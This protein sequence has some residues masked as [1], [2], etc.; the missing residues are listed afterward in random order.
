MKDTPS[1]LDIIFCKKGKIIDICKGVPFSTES[2]G[3]NE[4]SD[5]VIELPF[6]HAIKFKIKLGDK[7]ELLKDSSIS[8]SDKLLKIAQKIKKQ[9]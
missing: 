6:G 2:V 4:P 3:P 7:V 8:R 9:H 1:P 5:M